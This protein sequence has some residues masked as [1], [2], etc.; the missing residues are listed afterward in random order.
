MQYIIVLEKTRPNPLTF[1]FLVRAN[2]PTARQPYYA[3]AEFVS[4]YP[5]TLSADL[6]AL[7]AGQV[8]EKVEEMQVGS[9][10]VAQIKTELRASQAAFQSEIDSQAANQWKYYGTAWDGTAWVDGGVN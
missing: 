6:V 8:T 2:V 1:R 3:D 4:A 9:S 5:D 10:T 7:R